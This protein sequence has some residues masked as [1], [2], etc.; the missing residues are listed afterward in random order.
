[1]PEA[2]RAGRSAAKSAQA[3]R[4]SINP[5]ELKSRRARAVVDIGTLP[6]PTEPRRP[7]TLLSI[8]GPKMKVLRER[9]RSEWLF[10]AAALLLLFATSFAN[11]LLIVFVSVALLVVGSILLPHLRERGLIAAV[12]ALAAAIVL[13]R[14]AQSF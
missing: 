13:V 5:L 9:A 7:E 1:M 8:G 2:G 6:M 4:G 10:V 11:P 3:K 14:L 12:I